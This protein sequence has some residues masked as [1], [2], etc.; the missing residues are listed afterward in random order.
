MFQTLSEGISIILSKEERCLQVRKSEIM[1][2]KAKLEV[3]VGA[4]RL[5]GEKY[6]IRRTVG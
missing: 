2:K 3:F 1:F 5:N 6:N 4:G